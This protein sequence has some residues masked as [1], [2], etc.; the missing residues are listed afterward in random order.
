[1]DSSYTIIKEPMLDHAICT[2]R[3]FIV[4]VRSQQDIRVPDNLLSCEYKNTDG[5]SA[6]KRDIMLVTIVLKCDESHASQCFQDSLNSELNRSGDVQ[7]TLEILPTGALR[8]QFNVN[9]HILRSSRVVKYAFVLDPLSVERIDVLESKL[10]YQQDE[11]ERLRSK[12][13]ANVWC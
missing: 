5:L 2:L 7:R 12:I 3:C 9:F 11:L 1:M 4:D 8:L 6:G 10:W 13:E